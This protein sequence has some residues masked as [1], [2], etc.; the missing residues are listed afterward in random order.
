M[1]V[2]GRLERK[3]PTA[4]SYVE[5]TI[6]L[7]ERFFPNPLVD[8]ADIGDRTFADEFSLERF[9]I[10]QKVDTDE[11]FDILSKTGAWK[12]PGEDL[13]SIGFLKVCGP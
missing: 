8:L 4:F 6:L 11:I 7:K 5:K 12:A 9:M 13:L 1:P 10:N 2:F 3:S